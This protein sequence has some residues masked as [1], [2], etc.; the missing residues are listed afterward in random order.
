MSSAIKITHSG[1]AF[2]I[3]DPR[4]D[5]ID[6][7]DIFWG[8]SNLCR[9]TGQCKRFYSVAEHTWHG[10]KEI[11]S[12]YAIEWLLHDAAEAYIGDV[13]KELKCWLPEYVVI[14][15]RIDA[16]IRRTFSLPPEMSLRVKEVDDRMA[17]TEIRDVT[18]TPRWGNPY[19]WRIPEHPEWHSDMV[20]T[21]TSFTK[22]AIARHNSVD[23]LAGSHGTSRH[24]Q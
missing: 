23:G 4:P 6:I 5:M 17:A 18:C 21:L 13:S 7:H 14:E 16:V 22:R 19:E 15:G 3:L 9:F 11:D 8:L 24:A 10:L 1:I 2:D 12:Q 20:S